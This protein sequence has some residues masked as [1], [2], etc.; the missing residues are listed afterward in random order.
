MTSSGFEF[1]RAETLD[2]SVKT[3]LIVI[4]PKRIDLLLGISDG[5]E[6]VHVHTLLP[7]NDSMAA[8]SV[9]FPRRE[10]LRIMPLV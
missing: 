10:K 5:C 9:G 8:L 2:R 7:L 6:P 1:P 3:M 4:P